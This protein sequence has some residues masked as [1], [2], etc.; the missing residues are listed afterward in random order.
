[1][2]KPPLLGFALCIIL[3]SVASA[4]ATPSSTSLS[5]SETPTNIQTKVL[6][7]V[8]GTFHVLWFVPP[9]N[10]SY[11]QP[12]IW[13]LKYSPN[14]T[15]VIPPSLVVNSTGVQ[16]TDAAVDNQGNAIITW[17]EDYDS[18][19][20]SSTLNLLYFNS[21]VSHSVRILASNES[22]I[23]WPSIA[24]DRNN[25]IY[26]VWT[27]YNP[28]SQQT[29]IDFGEMR[30]SRLART[31]TIASY[32]GASTM[33]PRARVTFD[34]M[35]D[36]LHIAWGTSQSTNQTVSAV[37]YAKVVPNG[38]VVAQLQ[39]AKFDG[40][41]NDLSVTN[42]G[43]QDGAFVVWQ[44]NA[45]GA[46]VYVSQISSSGRL[47]YL[48]QLSSPNSQ[49]R[50]LAV[51]TDSENNL[52]VVWYQPS[53]FT[54]PSGQTATQVANVAYMQINSDGNVVQTGSESFQTP[55]IAATVATN[56]D[57]YAVLKTGLVKV[58]APHQSGVVWILVS[59]FVGCV[60]LVGA[61][62]TEEGKYRLLTASSVLQRRIND[63]PQSQHGFVQALARN[64]G[65]KLRETRKLAR[66][67]R[68]TMRT[69]TRLEKLGIVASF[70]DGL[71]RRFYVKG[72]LNGSVDTVPTRIM[73]H[74]LEYPGIW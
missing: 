26:L 39:V 41:V 24:L 16:S 35:S 64:P 66:Q 55:L 29:L 22:A 18:P 48:K 57:L 4:A 11:E 42:T 10:S 8:N 59:A 69:L 13:Y 62:S 28:H 33:A 9:Q 49:V 70:R 25:T 6:V 17:A 3:A 68:T 63:G 34:G 19:E 43:R 44:T 21:T 2:P 36:H 65:L 51:S 72:T 67:Y 31:E 47:V 58:T 27:Q 12:G 71:S 73:L 23:I 1:M 61:F 14:G 40:T 7:D 54:V 46:P 50:Y 45:A 32:P 5:S 53:F 56:G 30:D 15:D 37:D 52:Y 60:A 20:I 74:I 38:T